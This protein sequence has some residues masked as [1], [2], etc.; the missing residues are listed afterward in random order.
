MGG[1]FAIAEAYKPR[2]QDLKS[3]KTLHLLGGK[4]ALN[5][6]IV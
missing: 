2:M 5:P 6:C 4:M 1:N 3:V